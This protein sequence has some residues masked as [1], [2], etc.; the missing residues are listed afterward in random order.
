SLGDIDNARPEIIRAYQR[1][2]DAVEENKKRIEKVQ[3]EAASHTNSA[4]I[5]KAQ[6]DSKFQ[7]AFQ[8]NYAVLDGLKSYSDYVNP[9]T[10]YLDGL[11]FMANA[12]DA[13][14]LERAH[15]SFERIGG[16]LGD[17]DYI[18]EDLATVDGLMNGKRL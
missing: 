3:T 4:A 9:F 7:T 10:V 6:N 11:Y 18:R 5:Q 16:F 12:A 8:T 13:S 14:D 17:N 2:Q 1:Q 15:K